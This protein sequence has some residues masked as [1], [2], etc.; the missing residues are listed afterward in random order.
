MITRGAKPTGLS[1]LRKNFVAA[2][3]GYQEPFMLVYR[4]PEVELLSFDGDDHLVQVPL[5]TRFGSLFVDLVG[6]ALSKLQAPASDRFVSHRDAPIEHHFF[7]IP[8]AQR[9]SVI[10]PNT[11]ADDFGGKAVAKE[12]VTHRCNFP[13]VVAH[14]QISLT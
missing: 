13:E 3:S 1:N 6:I 11:V 5:I 12:G 4:S 8:E 10:Q 7:N 2:A 14:S 9:E